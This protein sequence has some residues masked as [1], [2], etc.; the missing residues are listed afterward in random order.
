[1]GCQQW[2]RGC[3]ERFDWLDW[4]LSLFFMWLFLCWFFP[5]V[6]IHLVPQPPAR[7]S[8]VWSQG[9]V[10]LPSTV[11]P[12]LLCVC[13]KSVCSYFFCFLNLLHFLSSLFCHT[14]RAI[15]GIHA[16]T[17]SIC[18]HDH[19]RAKGTLRGHG[20]CSG[21]TRRN[22]RSEWWRG[23]MQ[24]RLYLFVSL[25]GYQTLASVLYLSEFLFFHQVF[26]LLC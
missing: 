6:L 8:L 1:M 25:S 10:G 15:I 24:E 19:V 26:P 9:D 22:H 17:A 12:L 18:K 16:S 14:H 23:G 5:V 4:F 3:C 13:V 2:L 11:L 7:A 20:V 21:W